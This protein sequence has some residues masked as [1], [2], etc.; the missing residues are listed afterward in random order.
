[1]IRTTTVSSIASLLLLLISIPLAAQTTTE[2]LLSW[3]PNPE[4]DILRYV[5]FRSPDTLRAHFTAIDSVNAS[6]F[7]YT[8]SNINK[9]VYYFY[10]LKARN[11]AGAVSPFSNP[12]SIFAIPQDA[13]S[14]VKQRC[15]ITAKTRVSEGTYDLTWT[16]NFASIGFVQYGGSGG[17]TQMSPWSN[18]SYAT[19]H[20]VR[21]SGLTTPATYF[22]RATA[23]D[24]QK[25][26]V[27]SAIDTIVVTDDTP[28]PPSAPQLSVYPVPYNPGMGSSFTI[29]NLPEGGSATIYSESGVEVKRI[30]AGNNTL[31]RWDG[32]NSS[33]SRVMSGVYYVVIKDKN[34]K[35]YD[36]RPIM[37]VNK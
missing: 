19:T 7:T 32:K 24:T 25:N 16:N 30:E 27:I 22:V 1:M 29:E 15:Q 5:V 34:G 17:F 14:S 26:M 37:V 35:V 23:Y 36:K 28:A 18:A 12:V 20:T 3:P 4:P 6:T 2:V 10:R 21:I 33:G 8:N 11:G 13:S 9:G 31:V